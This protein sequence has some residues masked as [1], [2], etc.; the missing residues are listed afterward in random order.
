A[1]DTSAVLNQLKTLKKDFQEAA[2]PAAFIAKAGSQIPYYNSY[3][4]KNK[5]KMAVKDS[6]T[7]LPV[8]GVFG[9][10][11]DGGNYVYAKMIGIKQWP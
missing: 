6:I 11:L 7:K 8:G 2:D 1:A 9:P 5:L 10:Y 4:S 3:F